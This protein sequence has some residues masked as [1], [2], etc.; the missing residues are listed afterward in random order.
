MYLLLYKKKKKRKE[1]D[2][3]T[4]NPTSKS[5][6]ILSLPVSFRYFAWRLICWFS[7]F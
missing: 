2:G 6:S 3:G 4:I 7:E 5:L 1:K